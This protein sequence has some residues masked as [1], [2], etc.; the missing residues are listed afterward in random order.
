MT[1][2]F[3]IASVGEEPTEKDV[4]EGVKNF[5]LGEGGEFLA[6]KVLLRH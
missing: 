1:S 4:S 3:G 5:A 2:S 6:A